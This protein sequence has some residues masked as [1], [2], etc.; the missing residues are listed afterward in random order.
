[1][2]S[3]WDLGIQLI[4]AF[5]SLGSWLEAPMRAFSLLGQQEFYL[6]V[7]PTIYWCYDSQA[8]LKV[9]L[10]LMLSI[11][12]NSVFKL[13]FLHPRPY[14]YSNKVIAYWSETSFGL[15]S[16]H[17]MNSV[18][19]FGALSREIRKNW[20]YWTAGI[21]AFLVGISRIYLAA[22]FP[23]DVLGGWLL[24]ILLLWVVTVLEKPAAAWLKGRAF[25]QQALAAFGVS[26]LIILP[27]ALVASFSAGWEM[28]LIWQANIIKTTGFLFPLKAPL[29]IESVFTAG[30]AFFGLALGALWMARRGGFNA[31]SRDIKVIAARFV[32]GVVIVLALYMGLGVFQPDVENLV[33]YLIRYGRY[34]LIGVWI[35]AGAPLVFK[36]LKI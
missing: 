12:T 1:M 7:A 14:W 22:H 16:G 30:G 17:A 26:L 34:A 11:G 19:L 5:Q 2:Q 24:G 10:Y 15:P 8:G 21:V 3:I 18:V 6:L 9:G 23:T 31:R 32:I 13:A 36:L 33:S 35:S 4:I 29:S 25:W 20:A 28:P 27:S